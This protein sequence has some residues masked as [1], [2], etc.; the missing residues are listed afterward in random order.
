M[1][2]AE[3]YTV[4]RVVDRKLSSDGT[5]LLY[6]IRWSGFDKSYDSWRSMDY[7]HEI[8]PL[9]AAYNRLV[10]LPASHLPSHL[11]T[12][13]SDVTQPPPEPAALARHHFRALDGGVLPEPSALPEAIDLLATY[14]VGTAVEMLYDEDGSLKWYAG[15]ITRCKSARSRDLKPDLSYSI[16]FD[17]N[18]KIY[19]PYKLSCNSL[20]LL[21]DAPTNGT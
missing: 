4:A 6:R 18:S 13:Q 16:R 8:A 14:S 19:G 17:D 12:V 21:E 1:E 10:P 5:T 9:V 7:L 3:R 11:Q 20:R 15:T 2:L